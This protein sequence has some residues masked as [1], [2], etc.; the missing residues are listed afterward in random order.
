MAVNQK[1]LRDCLWCENTFDSCS[2][3]HSKSRSWFS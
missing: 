1:I 3:L 2:S